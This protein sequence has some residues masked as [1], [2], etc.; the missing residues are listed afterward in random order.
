MH[1][2]RERQNSRGKR[3]HNKTHSPQKEL[4][5]GTTLYHKIFKLKLFVQQLFQVTGDNIVDL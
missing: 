4:S 2:K 5:R 3:R 1:H